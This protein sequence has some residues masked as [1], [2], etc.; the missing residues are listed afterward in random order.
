[1]DTEMVRTAIT[2]LEGNL[3][4]EITRF[5]QQTNTFVVSVSLF[6]RVESDGRRVTDRV[7]AGAMIELPKKIKE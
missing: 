1:M 4:A 7:E 5:E 3:L 6:F 2:K